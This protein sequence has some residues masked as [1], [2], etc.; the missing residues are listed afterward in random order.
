MHGHA[1]TWTS[2][3]FLLPRT[4]NPLLHRAD[5]AGGV[6]GIVL[7]SVECKAWRAAKKNVIWKWWLEKQAGCVSPFHVVN[8][9]SLTIFLKGCFGT[10]KGMSLSLARLLQIL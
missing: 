10:G 8:E 6:Q 5:V 1:N 9:V 2:S 7:Q 4:A 3:C